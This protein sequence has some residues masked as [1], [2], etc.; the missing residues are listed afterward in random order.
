[1]IRIG[2]DG[3]GQS[4]GRYRFVNN[5]V[6]RRQPGGGA[7]FRLFD[8]LESVEAHNNVFF[9][10]GGAAVNLKR[11]VEAV[12]STGTAIF[13]GSNNWITTGSTNAPTSWSG[14]LSGSDPRFADFAARNVSPAMGSPLLQAGN[15]A[16]TS[17][18]AHE[19]PNPL[20]RPLWHPP[21]GAVGAVGTAQA[22]P[23]FG[24][25]DIGA[26]EFGATG[27]ATGAGG[28]AGGGGAAGAG[29]APSATT[30]AGG[31]GGSIAGGGGD[32]GSTTSS[33]SGGGPTGSSASTGGAA[34]TG[35][36][37]SSGSCGCRSSAGGNRAGLALGVSLAVLAWQR[38]R[39]RRARAR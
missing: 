16:P 7:V 29:G 21:M 25:V 10:T 9:G 33:A 37:S 1:M 34:G 15:D 12:W 30:G 22:R 3:T 23:M 26:F 31:S 27:G 32:A 5:T 24:A 6:M 13:G 14:T 8:G 19:F 18:M 11:E 36:A 2:G 35:G 39:E 20:A 4:N 38:R 17:P 28:A